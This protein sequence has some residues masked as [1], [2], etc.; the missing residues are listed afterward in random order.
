[1]SGPHA[2]ARERAE[3]AAALPG[4][5]VGEEL[6]RGAWGIVFAG[7]H[8]QL[9]RDVAI[10][11][12][13][14]A[15]A[16][17]LEVRARFLAEGRLLAALDHAHIVPI[18][19]F[20]EREGLCLLV[21]ERLS[22]GTVAE[23]T[24]LGDVS[25]QTAC[26]LL[27]ATC[28][29]LHEA[30][31]NHLLHRDIKPGN[32]MFSGS[33]ILKVTDF[34][35]A[36][37]LGGAATV[38][39]RAGEVLGTPA[40][41]APEQVHGHEVTRST[42]VYAAGTILFE[43]LSGELPFSQEGNLP[44]VLYR[45]VSEQ[46]RPLRDAAPDIPTRFAEITARALDSDP[47]ERYAS[48]EEF[49]IAIAEA[50]V[51]T[52]GPGWL[53][54]TRVPLKSAGPIVTAARGERPV[55]VPETV[56]SITELRGRQQ[57]IS[58]SQLVPLHQ[59]SPEISPPEPP[60]PRQRAEPSASPPA[61]RNTWLRPAL[62]ALACAAV[63]FAIALFALSGDDKPTTTPRAAGA[64]A[65]APV[66]TTPAAG[67]WQVVKEAPTARQQVAAADLSG[68]IWV[69]GG[70]VSTGGLVASTVATRKTE[71][72]DPAIDTWKGGP[73][74]P[75]ALHHATAV[76]YRGELVVVG[77][78]RPAGNLK[79]VASN[80]VFALRGGQ[81]VELPSMRQARAAAGVA[82]VGDEI[83]ATG[84]QAGGALVM[85]TE[86]FDGT[87]WRSGADL[88]TPRE[89]LTAA[90]DGR[91]LYAVGGRN[92]SSDK[93][94]VVVERYDP[95]K[96]EW[97]E[98]P[99]KPTPSGGLG[100]VVVGKRLIALGGENPTGTIPAVE[101]LDLR[102][103]RWSALPPMRTPRHGMG[104]VAIGSTLFAIAG[105]RQPTHS[106]PTRSVEALTLR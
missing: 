85:Q 28:A 12:L 96:D 101:S 98:L 60:E 6:G 66:T 3:V 73:D 55:P 100:S 91:F 32:L 89:H 75:V 106:D 33:G 103:R 4:F 19:D 49:G 68:T 80:R 14:R 2:T 10:K 53:A 42:D 31:E 71:A 77:G 13:P 59:L 88:P 48:A 8:R 1:M 61:G 15:F 36:K 70:L 21:M 37:V 18:Y 95:A 62:T 99:D 39:T 25:P 27:L 5:D 72:Y 38:A 105:A 7:R 26:A 84:G 30:H 52:W 58:P 81:W 29:G 44:A 50:A 46:P 17:D 69:A 51:A 92:L 47:G 34:G 94:L 43:L 93:N 74:L 16:A 65:T 22:G 67:L 76:A 35:I 90:S 57:G 83:V 56:A 40:Y 64:G 87:Q 45:R 54:S 97:Q 104:V 63:G 102:S 78:F 23:R 41:M 79:A 20:V 86:R 24:R 9:G 11:E 82:A